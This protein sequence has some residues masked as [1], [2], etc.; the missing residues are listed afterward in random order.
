MRGKVRSGG[1]RGTEE[2]TLRLR[3]ERARDQRKNLAVLLGAAEKERI[4]AEKRRS[5]SVNSTGSKR[6]ATLDE[7]SNSGRAKMRTSRQEGLDDAT[8]GQNEDFHGYNYGT[9]DSIDVGAKR[10]RDGLTDTD[11]YGEFLRGSKRMKTNGWRP[12]VS[13][14]GLLEEDF[15]DEPWKLLVRQVVYGLFQLYPTPEKLM[16]ASTSELETLLQPLGLFRKRAIAIQRFSKEYLEKDWKDPNELYGIGKYASDAY[17][18]FCLGKWNEVQPEDKDLKLYLEFVRRTEGL[19]VG[20][21]R[22]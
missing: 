16:E 1:P 20:F 14:Y 15:F 12:P 4:L 2:E 17:A 19:G 5:R 3:K 22:E 8:A 21:M 9:S 18:I 7:D 11:N 6:K 13:P 10:Q